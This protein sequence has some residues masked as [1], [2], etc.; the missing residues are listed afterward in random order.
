MQRLLPEIKMTST[1][2][3]CDLLR[4]V[5]SRLLFD[6][7]MLNGDALK[8]QLASQSLHRLRQVE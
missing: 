7:L 8:Q 3:V 4:A 1:T 2:T 5:K 6:V